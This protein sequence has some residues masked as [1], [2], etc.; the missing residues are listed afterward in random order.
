VCHGPG[1][2]ILQTDKTIVAKKIKEYSEKGV[3]FYACEFAMK[4][5]KV[6]KENI[7]PTA[8][9]VKSG[10]VEIVKKQA[11]GWIYIKAGF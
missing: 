3:Q 7:L 6:T 2:D 1:L 5:R 4:E 10:V 9:F 11:E 8:G